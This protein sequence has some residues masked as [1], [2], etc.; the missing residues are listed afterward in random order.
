M[1]H[2]HRTMSQC[3]P[4]Y[5]SVTP[6]WSTVVNHSHSTP[7]LNA[8]QPWSMPNVKPT[9]SASMIP[10]DLGPFLLTAKRHNTQ[11]PAQCRGYRSSFRASGVSSSSGSLLCQ[12]N[13]TH[14]LLH[15]LRRAL[16][17][18]VHSYKFRICVTAQD[19]VGSVLTVERR[20]SWDLCE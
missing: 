11:A 17:V 18:C 6:F 13:A 2:D 15:P 10:Q 8:S 7:W 14:P 20:C 19:S 5:F 3:Y 12:L 9:L 1:S 4:P 16:Y